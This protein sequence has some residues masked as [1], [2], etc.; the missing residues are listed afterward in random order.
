M[1]EWVGWE[2]SSADECCCR[3]RAWA[4]A[5]TQLFW[6]H[7]YLA[8]SAILGGMGSRAPSSSCR[9]ATRL[10]IVTNMWAPSWIQ[11]MQLH[12]YDLN[13]TASNM[14]SKHKWVI[15]AAGH[16]SLQSISADVCC[17]RVFDVNAA[18]A[19]HSRLA[20]DCRFCLQCGP[21][22]QKAGLF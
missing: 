3:N 20:Q 15:I 19:A 22:S 8:R 16:V 17:W 14:L 12:R 11:Y 5:A 21:G 7:T 9:R 2:A 13:A 10:Y 6:L 1:N 18:T 4:M